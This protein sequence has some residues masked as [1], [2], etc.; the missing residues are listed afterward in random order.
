MM[1]LDQYA[2]DAKPWRD[3]AKVARISAQYLWSSG[4]PFL[5]FTAA[6]LGHHALEMYL[7]AALICAGMTVFNPDKIPSLDPSLG[8]TSSDCAWKHNLVQLATELSKR[9]SK[10]DLSEKLDSSFEFIFMKEGMTIKDG[11]VL[12]DSYFFDLRYPQELTKLES[13][14]KE[15]GNLLEE[16]IKKIEPFID[17][18]N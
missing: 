17:C 18:V 9:R 7:K 11:F 13:I 10:F 14:G 8:V 2:R 15:E 3:F 12:F 1:Q 6:T 4:N 16:L 5:Y